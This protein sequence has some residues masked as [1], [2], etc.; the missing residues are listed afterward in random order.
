MTTFLQ[1]DDYNRVLG[2]RIG[3]YEKSDK[4]PNEVEVDADLEIINDIIYS[5]YDP[6]TK[7]FIKDEEYERRREEK[8]QRASD[9]SIKINEIEDTIQN[10]LDTTA[11]KYK[12]D[13]IVSA[14]SYMNSLNPVFAKEAKAFSDWRDMVWEWYINKIGPDVIFDFNDIPP[15]VYPEE[16]PVANTEVIVDSSNTSNTAETSNTDNTI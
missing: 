1:L 14:I 13:N 4:S 3:P 7:T 9:T 15:F 6:E 8:R 11:Q 10:I 5:L 12:Y 2:Y 16:E